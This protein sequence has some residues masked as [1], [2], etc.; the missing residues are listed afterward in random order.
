M[1]RL[2]TPWRYA[3][4]HGERPEG[5]IFCAKL[6]MSD[7]DG[8]IVH[9]GTHAYVCLNTFPYNNGH[10]MVVPHAHVGSLAELDRDIANEIMALTQESER[11]LKTVYQP[12][13]INL[14]ANLGKAA[15]AGVADHVHMHVL[16]RWNGDGNFMTTV[17][18][19]RVL[20]EELR[21]TWRRMREG[22]GNA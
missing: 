18:E 14:G 12:D 6:S 2:Y 1:D 17:A 15:G 13:G 11:V 16:P 20:P 3:F 7:E 19:T 10:V 8:L 9:R 22:F 4:I 21:T 5:C